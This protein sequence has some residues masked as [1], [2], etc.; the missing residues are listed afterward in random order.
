MTPAK[1][2]TAFIRRSGTYYE[3]DWVLGLIQ[4][5]TKV[6]RT[7]PAFT[8]DDVWVEINR[9][10]RKG[11]MPAPSTSAWDGRDARVLGPIL[12]F[13]VR[14]GQI[15]ASG[16][17]VRSTRRGGGH[18]PVMLWESLVFTPRTTRVAA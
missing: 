2:T 12:R 11:M 13:L 6:A 5:I 1:L 15:T 10:V 9:R 8:T 17:Y 7:N 18:R 4:S 3:R 14:E 16:Y